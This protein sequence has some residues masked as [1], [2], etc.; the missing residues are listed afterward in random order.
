MRISSAALAIEMSIDQS[1][2]PA[3]LAGPGLKASGAMTSGSRCG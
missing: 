1:P 2:V 3:S